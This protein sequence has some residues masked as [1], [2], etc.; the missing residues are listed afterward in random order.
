MVEEGPKGI[1]ENSIMLLGKTFPSVE[2][3]NASMK[4]YFLKGV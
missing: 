2:S 3:R 1:K 4:G